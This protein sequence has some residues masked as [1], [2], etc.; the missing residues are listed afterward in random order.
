MP[1]CGPFVT[2]LPGPQWRVH[3]RRG[4]R[5]PDRQCSTSTAMNEPAPAYAYAT[6]GV[7][8][9]RSPCRAIFDVDAG[10]DAWV[11]ACRATELACRFRGP[12]EGHSERGDSTDTGRAALDR[13]SR[14]VSPT[15]TA[16]QSG[17]HGFRQLNRC[18]R[19]GCYAKVARDLPRGAPTHPEGEAGSRA[20]PGSE[21]RFATVAACE[22]IP[23]GMAG[24]AAIKGGT[25][26]SHPRRN[27]PR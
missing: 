9:E 24:A 3:S 20:P 22:V 7:C 15:R 21:R 11:A 16:E 14:R 10:S 26:T 23:R 8:D 2:C 25:A 1:C 5:V 13:L 12:S 4:F 27:A 6:R 17:H 19:S 18:P